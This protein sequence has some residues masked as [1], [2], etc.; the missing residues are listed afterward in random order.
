MILNKQPLVTTNL[1]VQSGSVSYAERRDILLPTALLTT[2]GMTTMFL[3]TRG[4][5]GT[6]SMTQGNKGG[7]VTVFLFFLP[8]PYRLTISPSTYGH[9]VT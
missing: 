2:T 8:S 5:L 6:K 4:I 7:S 3:R 1:S 9:N